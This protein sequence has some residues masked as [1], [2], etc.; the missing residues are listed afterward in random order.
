LADAQGKLNSGASGRKADNGILS[1][2][3]KRMSSLSIVLPTYNGAQFLRQ[4]I[5]SIL[6]QSD[7]SFDLLVMDD[8]STDDTVHIVDEYARLDRRIRRLPASGNV[9]QRLRL[10]KLLD[11]VSTEFVAF[12]DQDDVWESDRNAKLLSA[13]GDKA[14][15]F[16]RSRLIDKDGRYIGM[17]LLQGLSI[18]PKKASPLESLFRPLVSAHAAIIKTSWIDRTV[19]SGAMPFDHALGLAA[20][21]SL[22]LVYVDDAVVNHRIHGGNQMNSHAATQRSSRWLS[23]YRLKTSTS[24]V[25]LNRLSL[26]VILDQMSRSASIESSVRVAF[27]HAAAACR[28]AWFQPLKYE[29]MSGRKLENQLH[30]LLDDLSVS[31]SD[32]DVFAHRIRSVTGS[33]FS[34]TN[35]RG[36]IRRY[37]LQAELPSHLLI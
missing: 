28:Y 18:D 37:V 12:A 6:M 14:L 19:L 8:G 32:M 33:Q 25:L 27:A 23:L 5:E 2:K 17:S 24:F 21:L 31:A 3:E 26:F 1:R 16:G 20:Q 34:I 35:V 10:A 29:F 22:G 30:R 9:G 11:E 4:Q 13:I 15:A 7:P 36:A